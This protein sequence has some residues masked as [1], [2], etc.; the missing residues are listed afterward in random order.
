MEFLEPFLYVIKYKQG[1]ENVVVDALSRRDV[2][3]STLDTKLLSFEQIK[4]LN[5]IDQDFRELFLACEKIAFGNYFRHD[6]FLFKKN[7]LCVPIC[8]LRELLV[9]EAHG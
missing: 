8:S 6:G 7:K 5:S 9:R 4:E 1:K 2:L 3:L